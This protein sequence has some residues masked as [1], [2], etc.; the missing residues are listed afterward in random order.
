[1][2]LFCFICGLQ[3]LK[4]G[5]AM[6]EFV[7]Q[8][9]SLNNLSNSTLEHGKKNFETA[10]LALFIFVQ[11][12]SP[13]PLAGWD[14]WSISSAKAVLYSPD[15]KVPRTGELALRKAIPANTNMKAIQ[16]LKTMIVSVLDTS[17]VLLYKL[18]F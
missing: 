4:L 16:V 11:L 12:T 14:S 10:I 1:M 6:Q 8:Q 5:L 2:K 3:L 7:N 13:L 18:S 17:I 15:T 9:N